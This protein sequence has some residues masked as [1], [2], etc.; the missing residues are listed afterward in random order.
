VTLVI[1]G[2]L[3]T[4]VRADDA[5]FSDSRTVL[6]ITDRA[7][8][9]HGNESIAKVP[10]GS[11]LRYS[12]ERDK[13][14][15]IPRHQGW[16]AREHTLPIE[17]APRHFDQQIQ[18]NPTPQT[19]HH[20]GIARLELGDARGALADFDQAIAA[21]LKEPGV[22]I[23]RGVARERRGDVQAAIEDYT[24]ALQIDPSSARAYDNR[25]GA[26]AALGQYDASLADSNRALAIAPDFAEAWNNAG[27]TR[28]MK[29][30]F[31][32]AIANYSR[33]IEI[34]PA[35]AA[36]LGNRGYA[37]KRLGKL[38][39]AV[40]DYREAIRLD[41]GAPGAHNDLAWLLATSREKRFRDATT[42]LALAQR[43]C[44]LTKFQNADYVDT[45]AAAHAASGDF[46]KGA[47][48]AAQALKLARDDARAPIAE[49]L[50]L[51]K[52]GRAFRE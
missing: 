32:K 38:E 21:G 36:A 4:S 18:K 45:L 16:L 20:R 10:P 17:A 47:E 28:R 7:E 41:P 46:E 6:I 40:E 50:E 15:L 29:G 13:W 22:F 8:V 25:S 44:E 27:V 48:Y 33:A 51:Y 2:T 35:Y 24:R 52:S 19:W 12:K 31:G 43:A 1:A 37:H 3:R 42:A 11:V 26:L 39:E 34:F 5:P 49:R 14:L 30:E 9:F 23:N